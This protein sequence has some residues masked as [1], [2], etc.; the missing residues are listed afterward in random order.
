MDSSGEVK[1]NMVEVSG[2]GGEVSRE[3]TGRG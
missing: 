3:E 1:R 2:G